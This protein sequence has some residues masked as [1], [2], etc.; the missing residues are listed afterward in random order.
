MDFA[1][2]QVCRPRRRRSDKV[3]QALWKIY[4]GLSAVAVVIL[5]LLVMF[6]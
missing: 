5:F 2:D 6:S 4:R 3:R 1:Q